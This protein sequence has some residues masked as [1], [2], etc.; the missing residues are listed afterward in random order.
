MTM[1]CW[2]YYKG[3]DGP[4]LDYRTTGR[5]GV[6]LCVESGQLYV[7]FT[8]LNYP[9]NIPILRH[10]ALAGSWKFV[11][12]SFDHS[13][14]D[15]KL[16]V[17]GAVVYTLNIGEGL[18]LATQDSVR[19]GVYDQRYFKG[20][21]AQMQVY[22]KALTQEQIQAI[23]QQTVAGEYVTNQKIPVE[24]CT[25][26]ESNWLFSDVQFLL[27]VFTW[28]HWMSNYKTV[29]PTEILLSWCIRVAEN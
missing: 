19:M 6:H 16:W 25:F 17:N 8:S 20:R 26:G 11:G 27:L 7:H 21:I 3:Q 23:Q 4:L 24:A 14:G 1:L 22:D 9:S 12:A 13:T 5:A 15:A 2:V 18:E 28:R 10:T 29:D